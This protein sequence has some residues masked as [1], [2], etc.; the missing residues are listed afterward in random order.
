MSFLDP[1]WYISLPDYIKPSSDLVEQLDEFRKK[2]SFDH[3]IFFRM[4]MTMPWAVRKVQRHMYWKYKGMLS[5]LPEKE[6]WR[7]VILSRLD[8]KR[9]VY[10]SMSYDPGTKPLTN[11]QIDQI[12]GNLDNKLKEFNNFE[13]VVEYIIS[14]DEEEGQF[15]VPTELSMVLGELDIILFYRDKSF[16]HKKIE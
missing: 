6:I 1:K 15:N 16:N 11:Q 12:V 8:T 4:L 5:H 7:S 14:I 3:E 2:Y 13:D 10:F 9:K